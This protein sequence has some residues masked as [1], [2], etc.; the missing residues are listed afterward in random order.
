[1]CHTQLSSSS[2]ASAAGGL[3]LNNTTCIHSRRVCTALSLPMLASFTPRG[4]VAPDQTSR[5]QYAPRFSEQLLV[6]GPRGR[7]RAGGLARARAR[8]GGRGLL[9]A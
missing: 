5:S 3:G 6:G 2:W 8:G 1:M 4:S 7:F 9:L